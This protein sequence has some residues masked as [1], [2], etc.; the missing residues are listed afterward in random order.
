ML[1]VTVDGVCDE[2]GGWEG[3]EGEAAEGTWG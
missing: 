3:L 1:T 2:K